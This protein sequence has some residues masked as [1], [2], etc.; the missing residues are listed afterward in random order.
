MRVRAKVTIL[1]GLLFAALLAAQWTIQQRLV[2]PKFMEL[3]QES[4]RTDMQRVV[5]AVEREQQALGAQAAD[6]GNWNDTWRYMRRHYAAY[7]HD[8]L[9][10]SAIKTLKVDYLALIRSD[11]LI[12]WNRAL[13]PAS[14]K[15]LAVRL[16]RTNQLEYEWS[17]ALTHGQPI[18][19]L[20]VTNAGVLVAAG[21]PV[22]DGF[23]HGPARG[24][25]IIG[26]FLNNAELQRLGNQAQVRLDMRV[27]SGQSAADSKTAAKVWAG[28]VRLTESSATTRIERAFCN[29]SGEPLLIFGI[30]VPRTISHRGAEAVQ[31][32]TR[33]VAAVACIALI[34]LL[35]L[36]GRIVLSPLASVTDHAQRIAAADDLSARLSYVRSDEL[37]TLAKA[38]DNMVERL[39]QT[40]RELVDRSFES[41]AAENASG[42]LHNLGNA[43]TPLSVNVASLQQQLGT[44]S[45]DDLQQALHELQDTTCDAE[46]RRDL[47]QFLQLSV[48]E[49][50]RSQKVASERLRDILEQASVI[51]AVLTEQRQLQR[52][53]PV[54]LPMT[55]SELITLSLQQVA[56]AHRDRLALDISSGL[57]ALG[58]LSLPCTTLGMVLQNLIQNAAEAAAG[59]G[60]ERA[61]LRI[62][63]D[64]LTADGQQALRI[65][66]ADDAAG[67]AP[68]NISKLFEKGYST[69]SRAT[70][71]GLG[72]HWCANTL[73]ALG[74]S[75]SA[76]SDGLGKGTCFEVVVPLRGTQAQ[77][78]ERAA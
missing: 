49:L 65:T 26:R 3:E 10:D 30:S 45:V 51:Q 74:G 31:Y 29:L 53:G 5:Y 25:V 18:S 72:L 9:T 76:H 14:G 33:M 12:D 20:I 32:S 42:V 27:W 70:N 66:I 35:V 15:G 37:G 48:A 40:R 43:M 52:S 13:D 8:T 71:S 62:G 34:T 68:E 47:Q 44:M 19:G 24:M 11:G 16:N 46:R 69:K 63:A 22:L 75:I 59:S 56:Q 60:M 17:R 6:W 1:L 64:V 4:A 54:L 61:R 55:P 73:R 21:A 7:E 77:T 67:V 28:D 78:Q 58:S 38:F 57:A 2:L 39:A 50:Q 41:G 23:G 36:L